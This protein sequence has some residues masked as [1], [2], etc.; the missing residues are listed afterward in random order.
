MDYWMETTAYRPGWQSGDGRMNQ[1][2]MR[3]IYGVQLRGF[4]PEVLALVAVM[5]PQVPCVT[6]KG[7][8]ELDL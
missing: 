7:S 8:K 2:P 3:F 5:R 6:Q 1:V 4:P